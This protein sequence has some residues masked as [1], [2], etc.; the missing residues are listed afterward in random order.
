MEEFLEDLTYYITYPKINRMIRAVLLLIVFIML[1]LCYISWVNMPVSLNI[2][3]ADNVIVYETDKVN[4]F[5]SMFQGELTYMSGKKKLVKLDSLTASQNEETKN[6]AITGSVGTLVS[7]ATIIPV[8]IT[9]IEALYTGDQA[10]YYG[11]RPD[12]NAVSV[13][14]YFEDGRVVPLPNAVVTMPESV[15]DMQEIPVM[16][17]YGA[18]TLTLSPVGVA[19]IDVSYDVDIVCK[20]DPFDNSKVSA[21]VTF[22]N[23]RVAN[24]TNFDVYADDGFLLVD[25]SYNIRVHT[26]YGDAYL[27]VKPMPLIS[28]T[29]TYEGVLFEGDTIIRDYVFIEQIFD[30][31]TADGYRRRQY[32]WKP[33]NESDLRNVHDGFEMILKTGAGPVKFSAP[34][35]SLESVEM[36]QKNGKPLFVGDFP[37]PDYFIIRYSDGTELRVSFS[38][39]SKGAD[40]NKEQWERPVSEGVNTYNFTYKSK[41]YT[42]EVEALPGLPVDM[43]RSGVQAELD[44]TDKKYVS[45]NM[46]VTVTHGVD[47][48]MIYDLAHIIVNSPSQVHGGIA[49]DSYGTTRELSSEASKRQNWIIGVNGSVFNY[50]TCG[51]D[52]SVAGVIIKNGQIMPDSGEATTGLETV[53]LK[54]GV[55]YTP[56]VGVSAQALLDS[57][58]VNV[59][60]SR[61]VTLI[62]NGIRV[63][64]DVIGDISP[65]TAVGMVSPGEYYLLVCSGPDYSGGG[66]YAQLR[67]IFWSHGCTYAKCLDG[68]SSSVMIF[69][70][71][72]VNELAAGVERS[73]VDYLYFADIPSD[74]VLSTND[75]FL[76]DYNVSQA[77]DYNYDYSNYMDYYDDY[78]DYGYEA[79]DYDDGSEDIVIVD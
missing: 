66:T 12:Q 27:E 35:V 40:S 23:G 43:L 77:F 7:S 76:G 49:G 37:D 28:Q 57:G 64:T 54:N 65:R 52:T 53:I 39:I 1:V 60:C 22:E 67:D 24:Q 74:A 26:S 20:G 75:Y 34:V 15:R 2:K 14:V 41:N 4:T 62:S 46:I 10:L 19:N 32:D 3:L 13:S 9:K 78:D 70:G 6:F 5:S 55:M 63:N 44:A 50:D 58:A 73:V 68:G 17:D 45:S 59:F 79:D 33:E 8:K 36:I 16:T 18:T 21:T 47:G 29:A 51:L 69:Q 31:G 61:D 38:E 48:S 71:D 72:I 30:N 11:S 42:V 25:D 56:D